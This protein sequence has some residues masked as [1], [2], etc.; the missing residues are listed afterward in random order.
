MH[1]PGHPATDKEA[2]NKLPL[3]IPLRICSSARVD[4]N[5]RLL[6]NGQSLPKGRMGAADKHGEDGARPNL[7]CAVII[8]EL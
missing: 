7:H 1:D 2:E 8:A 5:C 3:L 4:I 6:L